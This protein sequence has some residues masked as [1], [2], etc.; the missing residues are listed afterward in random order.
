M[1]PG[2]A[3]RLVAR[4]RSP[5]RP[6]LLSRVFPHARSA[7]V[8]THCPLPVSSAQGIKI[9]ETAGRNPGKWIKKFKEAGLVVIHKCVAVR[10]ALTAQ[11]LGADIISMDGYECAGHPG[12]EDGDEEGEDE[13][14]P[15]EE[16]VGNWLLLPIAARKLRIPFIVS[17]GCGDG[18]QLA[19]AL[20]LG[21]AGMNMVRVE[22]HAPQGA[23]ARPRVPHT[24]RDPVE[25]RLG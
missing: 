13:E 15:G 6:P 10:H 9:V 4:S 17:G 5:L 3:P 2:H 11:R 20:C 21:A 23:S 25:A 14:H 22:R 12:E 16:E 7:R 24:M 1:A 19:A 8:L 18:R